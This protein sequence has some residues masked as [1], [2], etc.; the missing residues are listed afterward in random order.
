MDD[1]IFQ[2]ELGEVL[3]NLQHP[4]IFIGR[5]EGEDDALRQAF[6][7]DRGAPDAEGLGRDALRQVGAGRYL[8][9][10]HDRALEALEVIHVVAVVHAEEEEVQLARDHRLVLALAPDHREPKP[11]LLLEGG[12]GRLLEV[13]PRVTHHGNAD[14]QENALAVPPHPF[15]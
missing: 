9:Q 10:P 15:G 13:D 3:L 14:R 11:L 2:P 4:M 1:K 6:L 8:L 5:I 7:A 12:D